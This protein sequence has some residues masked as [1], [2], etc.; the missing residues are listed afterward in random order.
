M[1]G[2]APDRLTTKLGINPKNGEALACYRNERRVSA[3]CAEADLAAW[4]A[5][6]RNG[7]KDVPK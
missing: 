4:R 7:A 2:W 6:M 1:G 5:A 3:E